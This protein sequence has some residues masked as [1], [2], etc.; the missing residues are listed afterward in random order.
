MGSYKGFRFKLNDT[1]KLTGGGERV[2]GMNRRGKRLK[3]Y[4]QPS[5]GYETQADLMY[6]SMPVVVSSEQYMVVF[7]NGASGFLDMGATDKNILQME[8][9]GGRMSYLVV[10]GDT[11]PKLM[12][13]FTALTGRQPLPARWTLGNISARMGYHTQKEVESVAA[14]YR[15]ERIPLDALVLDLYWFGPGVTGS[16]GNLDW[17]YDSFPKPVDMMRKLRAD[18]IK[19][20]LI[21]EPFILDSSKTYR[22][23]IDKGLVGTDAAGKPYHYNFFFGRTTLLDVFAPKTKDWFWNIYKKHTTSGVEGWWGDLG[24]PE[25][26]PKDMRHINGSADEVHNLYGHEWAKLIY[27]GFTKDFPSKRP[28]ILMRSGFVGSQR[29]GMIPWSGD[30]NRSWGGLKPQVEIS[31]TMG[32]QGM[33]YMH[34]DLGGF[35]GSI[36]DS[37][38]YSRWLQYGVFQPVFRTHAQESVPPEPIYWDEATK[39]LARK[40]IEL[41]YRMLPYNYTLAY[42]NAT[43][44][45]PLMRPLF[46]EEADNASLFDSTGAY[47]WG[48]DFLVAPI[49]TKSAL[50]KSVYLP[51][52]SVWIDYATDKAYE[53]GQTLDVTT[54]S[55]H[56]PVFVKAGAFIPYCNLVQT[57]DNYSLDT[58]HV[59]YYHHSSVGS[60][61]G[62]VYHDDG[63]A[64]DAIKNGQ[65]DLLTF[66]SQDADNQLSIRAEFEKHGLGGNTSTAKYLHYTVHGLEKKPSKIFVDNQEL[67]WS[68]TAVNGNHAV[69]N[70]GV[71]EV[72]V[73]GERRALR[74]NH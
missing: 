41:R 7:D 17:H 26:H 71:L 40:A 34:S 12:Q 61:S 9:T 67:P 3:L 59:H 70:G 45:M 10:A 30:V 14:L 55:N 24:E 47:M 39:N 58:L 60:G 72:V 57:T 16:M 13:S 21:T 8:A 65:Y 44:G 31:L 62:V 5:Y 23:C 32:L 11:W 29:Y 51:K 56:L 46:F 35:A 50:K 63:N 43:T 36:Q 53:G 48:D 74:I 19:T 69:W 22:E 66:S 1:E 37:E 4:S 54:D 18:G 27:D 49:T 25:V 64:K 42:Q 28:A 33:A 6:Y 68:S 15:K 38:L 73:L 2:L 20:V 52:S